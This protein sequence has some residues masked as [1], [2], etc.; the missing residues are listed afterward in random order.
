MT[1]CWSIGI[2]FVFFLGSF[3]FWNCLRRDDVKNSADWYGCIDQEGEPTDFFTLYKL[4]KNHKSPV[5]SLREGTAY[6]YLTPDSATRLQSGGISSVLSYSDSSTN[7]VLS[8]FSIG[9]EKSMPGKTLRRLYRDYSFRSNSAYFFYNDEFPN[10]S[11]SL[12][13]GHTKGIL[14]MSELGGFWIIHS[15]PKYPPQPSEQYSY[16]AT[17]QRYGQTM[18]CISIPPLSQSQAENIGEQL[19][20]NDAHVYAWNIPTQL[21]SKYPI[22]QEIVKGVKLSSPPFYRV[23]QL[24]SVFGKTFTSFAK[25]KKFNEDLY[26]NLVA[27]VLKTDLYVESWRNGPEPL[28]SSCNASFNVENIERI[29]TSS[30]S[31]S[32]STH[33]DHSKWAVSQNPD[34]PYVCIGDINRMETQ[35]VRGGGTV[36]IW[37]LSLWHR[38]KNLISE[39]E[40]C[41]V[42][43]AEF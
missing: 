39:S 43:L 8:N 42:D 22:F 3:C 18:L 10:G 17:G 36:C 16:P 2:F 27:P 31:F 38:F 15:V 23:T 21:A 1:N 5:A 20:Q 37:S 30:A 33:Q 32:F 34:K 24:S 40:K 28:P 9:D 11:V 13:H 35:F 4:P 19:I 26:S 41:P 14:V 25:Y 7:W 12:S 29:E 6:I